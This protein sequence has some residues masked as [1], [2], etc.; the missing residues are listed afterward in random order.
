MVL[1]LEY[2]G[3]GQAFGRHQPAQGCP[4]GGDQFGLNP[5]G[6]G[7]V[8][9][10]V[11]AEATPDQRLHLLGQPVGRRVESVVQIQDP[12]VDVRKHLSRLVTD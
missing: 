4:M 12:S 11:L 8:G 7:V 10:E 1:E 5:A 6:T 3:G 9:T 2:V